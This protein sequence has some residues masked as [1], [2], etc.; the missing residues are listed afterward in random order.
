MSKPRVFVTRLIPEAGLDRVRDAC[1]AEIWTEPLPPSI[2]VVRE[3]LAHCQGLLSLLTEKIDAALMDALPDLKVVSNY[4]V[5]FNNID[6]AAATARGI[7]VGNTPGVL[8]EATADLAFTLLISAAR[9]VVEGHRY[10]LQGKWK[11]WEPRGHIG[12]DL[13]GRTI[14]IVG[15]GRIGHALAKRCRGGWDMRILYHDPRVNEPVERDLQASRVD[16][17]TLLAESDFISV[18]ADLN[19]T[20]QGMFN[21]QAFQRMK[22]TAVFVNTARGPL[23][24]E[25][26]LT[27][28]L[29]AGDIFAAGLDVTDPEPPTMD[30]PLLQLDNVIVLPHIASATV[31]SRDGMA[32]IAAENLI[33]GVRG[34]PLPRWVNPEVDDHRRA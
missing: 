11:T 30:N 16:F 28:A 34:E 1:D 27:A 20:T 7:C 2:D 13:M 14:G 6:I 25:A 23:V 5:G 32:R 24:V 29:Q 18:H 19:K 31:S 3:K 21:R 4:A 17:D 12:Q 33:A 10:T 26:D 15:M 9:R 8:T 22:S